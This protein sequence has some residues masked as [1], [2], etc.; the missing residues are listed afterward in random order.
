MSHMDPFI[1]NTLY[2][3]LSPTHIRVLVN[4]SMN[5]LPI[6]VGVSKDMVWHL[7]NSLFTYGPPGMEVLP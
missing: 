1:M 6:I 3:F 2:H 7:T 5:A 4:H